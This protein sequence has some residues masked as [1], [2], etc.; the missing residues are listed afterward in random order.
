[1][2]KEYAQAF[3]HSKK[4]ERARLYALARDHG[5][6][7]Y[8]GCYNP[9]VDVHHV[10]E[11]SPETIKDPDIAINPD[12]LVSLCSECH[13]RLHEKDRTEAKRKSGPCEAVTFDDEGRPM[14]PRLRNRV[15][16]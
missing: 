13:R 1:M 5:L 12:N 8:P 10:V 6:C 16:E 2:A 11:L 15:P 9:A 4:W 7:Q 14:A 3:Y